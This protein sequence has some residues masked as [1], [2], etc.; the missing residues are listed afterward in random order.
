MT[1]SMRAAVL[2]EQ[3]KPHPFVDSQP[4]IIEQVELDPPGPD[5]VLIEIRAAG[6]CHS[7]LSMIEGVRPRALPI[8]VGHECAGVV[9]EVGANVTDLHIDQPAVISFVTT[10]GT[11][12]QCSRGRPNLCDSHW[13]ARSS[14][15]LVS[16]ARRL[17]LNGEYINHHSGVSAF[18]EYAVVSRHAVVPVNEE[19]SMS[20]AALFGCAVMTGTGAVLN[21]A[22]LE[23]GSSAAVVGLGG[24]GLSA[25][26]GAVAAG[27]S[28]VIAI[29]TNADK[30]DLALALGASSVF[31]AC[32][33]DCADAVLDA[34]NGGVDY[35]FE[36]AGA[37]KAMELAYAITARGGSVI[38][39]G[40]SH[41]N[42]SFSI[43]HAAMVSDEKRIV[44]SYMGSCSPR[45]DIPRFVELYQR[46]Q[47]PVNRI[48]TRE[49]GFDQI[50]H[51]FDALAEG[52]EIR[53]TL[54]PR[55][56]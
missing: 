4:I 20:D 2:H 38:S 37:V 39:A 36:M 23:V 6:L 10:C 30:L 5:E 7:D 35:A 34:T 51:G 19:L 54:D 44:G 9:R 1:I 33:A 17:R 13:N 24:V 3:G 21:T 14:G 18:A 15:G 52:H 46:G 53:Q 42:H 27:A 40:L 22:R 8:V 29:D 28:S 45:R 41:F 12:L 16:G 25:L 49:I 32:D 48:R 47:L 56:Q 31:N 43:P 55:R 26:L 11:C 50:N